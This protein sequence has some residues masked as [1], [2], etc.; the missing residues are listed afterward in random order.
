[1]N[2]FTTTD[3]AS[4]IQEYLTYCEVQKRLDEKTLKAYRI[5]LRQFREQL[6]SDQ[7]AQIARIDSAALEQYAASLY[8]TRPSAARSTTTALWLRSTSISRRTCSATP[9]QPACWKPM[10]TSATF[11][12]CSATAPSTSRKYIRMSQSPNR[13]RSSLESIR[14][15]IFGC[16]L[17]RSEALLCPTYR[18]CHW[19]FLHNANNLNHL[20]IKRLRLSIFAFSPALLQTSAPSS[21]DA[22]RIFL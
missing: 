21:E 7:A 4:L 12:K 13:G 16:R 19:R 6:R 18:T 22:F 11:R 2:N 9:L 1:M 8:P 14:G 3:L 5:D 10:W 17:I 20:K 15:R